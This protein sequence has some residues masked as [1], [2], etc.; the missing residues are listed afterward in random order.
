MLNLEF[1]RIRVS[2]DRALDF[3]VQHFWAFAVTVYQDCKNIKIGR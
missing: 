2:I 1:H 3:Y